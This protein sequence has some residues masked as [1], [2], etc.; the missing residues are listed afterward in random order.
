MDYNL[1]RNNPLIGRHVIYCSRSNIIHDPLLWG[2]RAIISI[3]DTDAEYE[4]MQDLFEGY[5]SAMFL[6]FA[7]VESADEA[8]CFD[9]RMARAIRRFVNWH[10]NKSIVVHCFAGASRSAAVA[11]FLVG[12]L[13]LDDSDTGNLKHYNKLVY[14]TLTSITSGN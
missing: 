13:G 2:T 1:V 4:Q 10:H 6:K 11:K 7:D 14:N 12:Y 8:D 5:D 3:S 9:A